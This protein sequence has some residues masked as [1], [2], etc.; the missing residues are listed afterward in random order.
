M[1]APKIETDDLEYCI[2]CDEVIKEG[3]EYLPDINGGFIHYRCCGPDR[4][5]YVKDLDEGT[6]LGPGDPI[7]PPRIWTYE[8]ITK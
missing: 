7:P 6:P 3:D 2:A 4:E 8:P 1:G 5:S